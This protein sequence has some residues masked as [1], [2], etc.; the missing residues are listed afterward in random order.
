MHHDNG[1]LGSAAFERA[2]ERRVQIMKKNG[3]NA[4]RTSHN[5]PSEAFLNACDRLG[6]LVIDETFDIWERPKN[7]QDYHRFFAQWWKKD[8]ESMILRDRNHPSVIIWSIGNEINERADTSGIRIAGSIIE[9]IKKFDDTRPFTNAICEFWDIPGKPWDAT[10][11]AFEMLTIGGYNYQYLRYESDHEK[12]P[13]RIMMG[14]ESV[15]KDA[16]GNWEMVEKHP[17]VIGDFVWTGM[18]YLGE[19]GIGHTQYMTKDQQDVFAMTWPWFN[20][21]CGD[22]DLIGDKKPQML[23]RDVIWNNSKLELNVHPPIPEGKFEQVSYWG[24]PDEYPHWN[25]N[26]YEDKIMRVSAYTKGTAV[27]LFLNGRE[28]GIKEVS[29]DTKLTATFDLPYEPGELKAI[30]YENEK[31]IAE[32][33]FKTTGVPTAIRLNADRDML[34][35]GRRDIAYITIEVVD[36]FGQVVTD[37]ANTVNISV[38]G[39]GELIGSGNACPNDMKSMGKT[40][41]NVFHGK[42]LAIV[43]PLAGSGK[44]TIQVTGKGLTEAL[45]ELVVE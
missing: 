12:Y 5:P 4:I 32:K 44:I 17:Y 1:L 10:A 30:A 39:N 16:Y 21:W 24:W 19:T 27:R 20:S 7:P 33:I 25:W 37:A 28:I 40:T 18:D 31:E 38:S 43:R 15:P 9:H 45:H 3:F 42:A 2:E 13:Q 35:E 34:T 8:V 29:P 14:T 6:M 22:I 41:L 36:E 26:G 23:Y 11:G